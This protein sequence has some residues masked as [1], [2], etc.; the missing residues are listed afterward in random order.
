MVAEISLNHPLAGISIVRGHL[1]S[2][3]I[4]VPPTRVQSSLCR[5]DAL[6]VLMRW[7]TAIKRRVYRVRGAN[8]LWHMDGNEKLR[9]WGFYVHGC[10]DGHSRLIIYLLCSNNKRA[11]NVRIIFLTIGIRRHG[12]PSRV[13]ADFGTE[14]N[15]VE[16]VMIEHWGPE[17]RPYLRGR[18]LH[19]VRIE[20]LWRDVRKDTLESF[21][22]VFMYLEEIGSLDMENTIHRVCLF[23]V[24]QPRI[25]ASLE[26]TTNAW[27][28]HRIR[29]A[30]N[31]TPIAIYELSKTKAIRLG[32][33][34]SDPDDDITD[35]AESLYGFDPQ[36][37]HLSDEDVAN[38]I[39]SH[40]N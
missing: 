8:S 15:E 5:V 24:Y 3:G 32:Y 11:R 7:S 29:T 23:I 34:N 4:R 14:N 26:R 25:Q 19:N 22:Q 17:H 12:W 39:A 38:V 35:V 13:R 31:K 6:G 18:S 21:R 28:N 20:R 33:W 2:L 40:A 36:A 16:D 30:Q 9:P 1:L 37:A 27:N 10:I